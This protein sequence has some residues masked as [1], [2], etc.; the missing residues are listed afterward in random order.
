MTSGY[1]ILVIA[2]SLFI[3]CSSSNLR[4][5][6][7]LLKVS[8]NNRFIVTED[9]KPFFWMGDT[10]WL[11]FKKLDREEAEQY[12][13]DRK[14]KGFN[15]IQVMVLHDID[16]AVNTYGDSAFIHKDISQP[17]TTVGNAYDRE[18][19][20]DFW[21][22]VDFMIDLAAKKGIY[23]ALVPIWGSNTRSEHITLERVKKY[24][25][26]MAERFRDRK[27]IIWVNGGDIKGS[28]ATDIWQ[29]LGNTLKNRDPNHLITFHPFGRTQSSMWF[30]NEAWL[31]FNMFQS[32]HRRYDQD[33]TELHY[34]EDNWRYVEA[35]YNLKPI[36]P[37]LD[38]EPSYEGI[39]QGLHDTT[40]PYWTDADVR[41]YAYWSVFAGGFG[42]TYGH[43][44]IMQFYNAKDTTVAYGA[45]IFWQE[46]LNAPGAGQMKYLKELMLSHSFPD[47]TPDQSLIAGNQGDKYNYLPA[48]RGNDYA[49]IY[50]Y[51]GRNMSV[52]MGK[53]SG[54]QIK[55]SW[56]SPRDGSRQEIGIFENSGH[57]EFNPPGEEREGN[58]WVLIL[59]SIE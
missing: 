41:R 16:D 44:A 53:I 25:T 35:D 56:F 27:N 1:K 39:P 26:W 5:E 46:A 8:D 4:E 15:V 12:L 58:D 32:G 49:F 42:F 17:K 7:P 47:R 48:A 18:D 38:G 10:G 11:L 28:D 19:E 57:L 21:D 23:I 50:T 33:D 43:N 30:H 36:K 52:A 31:D 55:A 40:Q 6:T 9:G 22:H 2:V 3:A 45:K 14:N 37:T 24:G 29:L 51:T 20:Y 34:G 59:E 54:E 13:E